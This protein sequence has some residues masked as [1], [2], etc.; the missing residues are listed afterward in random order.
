MRVSFLVWVGVMV[1]GDK[2]GAWGMKVLMGWKLVYVFPILSAFS[3]VRWPLWEVMRDL[4]RGLPFVSLSLFIELWVRKY[5]FSVSVYC[6]GTLGH[7][8][9]WL[10]SLPVFCLMMRAESGLVK[11]HMSM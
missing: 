9:T 6:G 5:S 7:S 11:V 1:G 3:R 4:A 2:F 10:G 8:L